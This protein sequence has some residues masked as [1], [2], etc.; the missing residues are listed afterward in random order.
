MR[1][2]TDKEV[3]PGQPADLDPKG[4]ERFYTVMKHTTEGVL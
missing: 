4:T 2:S 3:L 1:Q